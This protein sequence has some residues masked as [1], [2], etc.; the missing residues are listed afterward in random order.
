MFFLKGKTFFYPLHVPETH[1][2]KLRPCHAPAAMLTAERGVPP[3]CPMAPAGRSPG[4]SVSEPRSSYKAT[5][6]SGWDEGGTPWATGRGLHSPPPLHT[7][8]LP[9]APT[10]LPER[11][12][13]TGPG[14]PGVLPARNGPRNPPVPP[15]PGAPLTA[16]PPPSS[17]R[18][19][20]RRRFK[21]AAQARRCPAPPSHSPTRSANP[22]R[23]RW[24]TTPP[25][26]SNWVG[27][28]PP[29]GRWLVRPSQGAAGAEAAAVVVCVTQHRKGGKKK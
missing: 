26:P 6:R 9:A 21:S 13:R 7:P 24:V 8:G 29:L 20:R 19:N 25:L 5:G 27:S 15:G 2:R 22:V 14:D 11:G 18:P 23:F 16:Q 1:S 28:A 4:S 17:A 12:P 10:P 3:T